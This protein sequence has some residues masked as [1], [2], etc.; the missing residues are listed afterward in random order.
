LR[1]W[2]IAA[3]LGG[4]VP[5]AAYAADPEFNPDNGPVKIVVGFQPGGIG[6]TVARLFSDAVQKRL[7]QRVVVEN[8]SGANGM[9]AFEAAA[10]GKAD[11]L[12]LVQCSTGAMAVSP[13]LPGVVLPIDMNKDLQP[14][15]RFVQ[16]N[17]GIAV[18]KDSPYKT[19]ADLIADAKKRPGALNYGH[20]GIGSLQHLAAEWLAVKAGIKMQGIAYRGTGPA[21]LE[22]MGGRIDLVVGSLGDFSG[23][24]KA[25]QV[26]VLT[27]IDDIGSPQFPDAPQASA[28]VPGYAVTGWIGVC[29]PRGLPASAIRWWEKATEAALA[30]PD[31]QKR[32]QDFG[33]TPGYEGSE[34][35]ARTI[36]AEQARWKAVIDAN[37]IRAE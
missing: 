22:L 11:G 28:T 10:K 37:N 6:D 12:A 36:A 32:L 18:P 5:A 17:W 31:L 23:Q 16:A 13:V 30:D 29:G 25:G 15:A 20:A 33:L 9:I 24:A 3:L 7:N 21:V 35:F 4:A 19:L 27:L 14:V 1:V 26:R 8:R 34:T 2:V